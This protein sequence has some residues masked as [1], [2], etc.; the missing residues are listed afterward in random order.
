MPYISLYMLWLWKNSK[1]N[2]S[3]FWSEEIIYDCLQPFSGKVPLGINKQS[4][5]SCGTII[6]DTEIL[7]GRILI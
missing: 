6:T 2:R 1:L 3:D 4:N 7:L 5:N